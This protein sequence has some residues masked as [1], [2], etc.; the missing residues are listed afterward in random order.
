MTDSDPDST[1]NIDRSGGA[2]L[3]AG[4]DINIGGDVV[5][6]D[7]IVQN[8]GQIIGQVTQR[9]LTA[10]E[11]RDLAR[12]FEMRDLRKGVT[13]FMQRLRDRAAEAADVATSGPYRGLLEYRL[14]D[15]EVFFGRATA[16][17]ALLKKVHSS[18]LTVLYAESGA[19]KTS[20]IQAGLAP[21]LIAQG[22]LPV[23]VRPYNIAP[24]LAVKR[25]FLPNLDDTPRLAESSLRD[26]L[27]RVTGVLGSQITPFIFLDQFEEFF[28]QLEETSRARFIEEL[29]ECLDDPSLNVRWVLA[30]RTEFFGHL[31]DFRPRIR[32]PFENDYRLNRLTRIEA[33]ESIAA[34]AARREL[35]FEDG[36]I[37]VIIDDL[38]KEEVVPPQV[39]LVCSALYEVLT[40]GAQII[41]RQLYNDL[42]GA[43][44]ILRGHLIRVLNSKLTT[45]R[46]PIAQHLLEALITSDIRRV[47][48]TRAELATELALQD[49]G[50]A[51]LDAI[52]SQL[53]E[54]RVLRVEEID[55]GLAYELAHDYLLDEMK[56][57][58]AVQARKQAEE[59]IA[60]GISN[61]KRLGTLLGADALTLVERQSGVLSLSPDALDLLARSAVAN[62]RQPDY[63]VR[64]L[65]PE[66]R[67]RLIEELSVS[68]TSDDRR[69]RGQALIILW[70]LRDHLPPTLY[71]E[72]RRR[73][74]TDKLL[75]TGR[76]WGIPAAL[77]LIVLLV[78][79]QL[80]AIEPVYTDWRWLASSQQTP[81][82]MG[83]QT[84]LVTTDP[85][86]PELIFAADPVSPTFCKSTDGGSTWTDIGGNLP[87]GASVH[88]IAGT[89]HRVYAATSQG[90]LISDDQGS[91]WR[92]GAG[93]L[94]GDAWAVAVDSGD[95][96]QVYV[97][98]SPTGVFRTSDGGTTW[99][100][101]TPP[102]LN[103]QFFRAIAVDGRYLIA[104]GERS[105]LTSQDAGETWQI[106]TGQEV[107]SQPVRVLS[108][109]GHTGRFLAALGEGG[110]YDADV[111]ADIWF[112]F[113][114]PPPSSFIGSVTG[115]SSS[116][117]DEAYYISSERGLLCLRVWFWPHAG[118]WQWSLG[119]S[120]PCQ[121]SLD[122][123][124]P[125]SP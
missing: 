91:R 39:Q 16:T 109:L 33:R 115:W 62:K 79:P 94:A 98:I 18:S 44:G 22:H 2:D 107:I 30:L 29:A 6:R 49:V 14:G 67:A 12:S 1:T 117:G 89:D 110:L 10:V 73:Y 40:P 123:Q 37:D 74:L 60:Q 35:A 93:P 96:L 87:V 106:F 27:T 116:S 46:R 88:G 28:T 77:L 50:P 34:P 4:R 54:S 9:P 3:N 20:L 47:M 78:I 43:E 121:G 75:K 53:V 23:Y 81:C 92:A 76:R 36:L 38:G 90:L 59:L 120:A 17:R 11:K 72:V 119:A 65:P 31:A 125:G 114:N 8:I 68:L 113:P 124:P 51:T 108:A 97:T 5:G 80:S 25:A 24:S 42:H 45:T 84:L 48:R 57:D 70:S 61:W 101:L 85:A 118:W 95:P 58:P 56:L 41:T 13:A 32:N 86:N 103:D 99:S 71:A 55:G 122:A 7:K 83:S 104:A 69:L 82:G 21:H 112:P 111:S 19:G 64:L 66:A 63:W 100:L 105:A 52:L 15:A 102:E 26:F